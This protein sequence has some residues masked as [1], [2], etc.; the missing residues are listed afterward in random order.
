MET[1][2]LAVRSAVAFRVNTLDLCQ[3]VDAVRVLPACMIYAIFCAMSVIRVE[4]ANLEWS[5]RT[6]LFAAV[7]AKG[8]VVC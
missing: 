4:M 2:V 7:T 8:I 3:S 5:V 1:L 6:V